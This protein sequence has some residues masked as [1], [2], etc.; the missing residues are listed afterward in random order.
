MKNLS[1]E[2]KIQS[3]R[4]SI[5]HVRTVVY[6]ELLVAGIDPDYLDDTSRLLEQLDISF[7]RQN[8]ANRFNRAYQLWASVPKLEG[9]FMYDTCTA[10]DTHMNCPISEEY[11]T[12]EFRILLDASGMFDTLT[13]H[14][15][16]IVVDGMFA[17]TY[18]ETTDKDLFRN[19]RDLHP[20]C[21]A[22]T[23]HEL[24]KL[25]MEWQWA[26]D[27][28]ESREPMAVLSNN[29]LGYLGIKYSDA[30]EVV[31]D[32][33]SL[34]DS[35]VAQFIKGNDM[36]V[37]QVDPRQPDSFKLWLIDKGIMNFS[38]VEWAN[39]YSHCVNI[40]RMEEKLKLLEAGK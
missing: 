35:F 38:R 4:E 36:A 15:N 10:R 18:T 7:S 23:I 5:E 26:Y 9:H 29:A 8:T 6:K 30:S 39:L 27:V 20:F 33:M 16:L 13:K 32:V 34:P 11:N 17:I 2:I 31:A 19:L 40:E 24:F 28:L 21:V 22:H 14:D 25:M 37:P 1:K 12:D 3:L